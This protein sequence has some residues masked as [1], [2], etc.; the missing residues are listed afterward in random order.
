MTA[1]PCSSGLGRKWLKE[2]TAW[3]RVAGCAYVATCKATIPATYH[4]IAHALRERYGGIQES[5]SK[6]WAMLQVR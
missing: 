3:P 4:V 6:R 1:P 5:V 2:T